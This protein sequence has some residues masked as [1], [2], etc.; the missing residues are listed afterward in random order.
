MSGAK[1]VM[2]THPQTPHFQKETNLICKQGVASV[3]RGTM[4]SSQL[5]H[6]IIVCSKPQTGFCVFRNFQ[7][8]NVKKDDHYLDG[9]EKYF[10][11]KDVICCGNGD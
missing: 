7:T 3:G 6:V 9:I 1:K 10:M 8:K 2:K 11:A 4:F 5:E